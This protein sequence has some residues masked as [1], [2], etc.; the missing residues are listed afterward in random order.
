MLDIQK[1][2][3]EFDGT[4]GGAVKSLEDLYGLKIKIEGD[5]MQLNYGMIDSPKDVKLVKECRGIILDTATLDVVC[6]PFFRFFNQGEGEAEQFDPILGELQEKL[7]GTCI[8][9]YFDREWRVSTRGMINAEGPM[10]FLD[11]T[12]RGLFWEIAKD[13]PLD[14]LDKRKNYTFELTAPENRILTPYNDRQIRLLMVRDLD[15][16][17]EC[18]KAEV[19]EWAKVMGVGRPRTYTFRSLEDIKKLLDEIPPFDEGFVL[20]NYTNKIDGNYQRVK[21][22]S[23]RYLAAS[24]LVG[25]GNED[26]ILR[27]GAMNE[28]R[29]VVFC[30]VGEVDEF[31][32]YFPAYEETIREMLRKLRE[33]PKILEENWE[34]LTELTEGIEDPKEKRKIFAQKAMEIS[35]CPGVLF[36]RLDNKIQTMQEGV[37]KINEEKMVQI[38]KHVA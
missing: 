37:D 18:D 20:V 26:S 7:D 1:Y 24:Y 21:I 10:N 12:F 28:K 34:I 22:K 15:T 8:T 11:L 14:V 4:L 31:C 16:L 38:L 3:R 32:A 6:M 33:L 5:R 35:P 25:A 17:E 23:P 2:L 19:D 27:P 30:R 9:L 36:L 13:I 29:L